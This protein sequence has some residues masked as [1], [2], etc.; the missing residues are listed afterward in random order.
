MIAYFHPPYL[1]LDKVYPSRSHLK[2]RLYH[3]TVILEQY[4]LPCGNEVGSDKS[5]DAS[6][7]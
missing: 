2:G 7:R 6:V 4:M 3:L 5:A 1:F